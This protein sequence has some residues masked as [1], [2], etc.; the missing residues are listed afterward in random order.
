MS[1]FKSFASA[2]LAELAIA[3]TLGVRADAQAS[4]APPTL[5]DQAGAEL[6][7]MTVTGYVAP[8]VG[9]GTQPVHTINQ[10]FIQ[11][12]GDQ[13]VSDVIQRLPQNI[14]SFTPVVNPGNTFSPGGSSV[15]LYG[16][17][18]SSTLVLIDG[19]RQTL[20]PY[21][22]SGFMPFVNLNNIPLPPPHPTDILKVHTNPL[23]A[24]DPISALITLIH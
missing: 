7:Q 18:F 24:S 9:D 3:V 11:R 19:Y 10:D 4:A 6:Q 17:G 23:Y 20:F 5:P 1:K 22:Q 14:G 13:T 15:S 21:P 12:Q 16:L 8:R 2:M